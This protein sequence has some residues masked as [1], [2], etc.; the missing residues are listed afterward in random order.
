VFCL[1]HQWLA[2]VGAYS[3]AKRWGANPLGCSVGGVIYSFSGF[4][5]G[6]L[7]WPNYSASLAWMPWVILLAERG[8]QRGGRSFFLAC[9]AGS[10]QMLSGTPEVILLT[11]VGVAALLAVNV[12]DKNVSAWKGFYRLA[13][14]VAFVSSISAAQIFPFLELLRGS[15]RDTSFGNSSW[16]MPSTGLFNL[17]LPLFQETAT[18]LGVWM[19][20]GQGFTSSYYLG[21]ATVGLWFLLLYKTSWKKLT[22]VAGAVFLLLLCL[23]DYSP[24]YGTIKKVFPGIGFMRFPMKFIIPMGLMSAIA[25][26][27]GITSLVHGTRRLR[28]S[29]VLILLASAVCIFFLARLDAQLPLEDHDNAEVWSFAW[30]RIAFC[31]SIGIIVYLVAIAKA[32]RVRAGLGF[33]LLILFWADF[34]THRPSQN[35]LVGS[36]AYQPDL[37]FFKEQKPPPALGTGRAYISPMAAQKFSTTFLSNSFNLFLINRAGLSEDANLLEHVPKTDGFYSLYTREQRQLW[38]ATAM[39]ENTLRTNLLALQSIVQMN[40]LVPVSGGTN[41]EAKVFNWVAAPESV[42]WLSGGQLP[43]VANATNTLAAILAPGFNPFTQIILDQND[44][45]SIQGAEAGTPEIKLISVRNHLVEADVKSE[46]SVMLLL[47]QTY[48][49]PWKC[50]IDGQSTPILRADH[51]FQS[52]KFPSGT[53]HVVFKYVDRVFYMGCVISLVSLAVCLFQLRPVRLKAAV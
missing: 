47:S 25:A 48:Y 34:I 9:L 29:F 1:F 4:M 28:L 33:A 24:V 17:I 52:V 15:Q 49:H 46:K 36:G 20:P 12:I 39:D 18:S 27:C 35:P 41:S 16:S 43:F 32:P 19:Q 5:L 21:G 42:P 44:L 6:C 38:Q 26:G 2:G 53:H 14:I 51:A 30:V 10:M 22:L 3:L 37:P 23:G 45:V 13:G 8:F 7:I 11:W 50:F 40:V 31:V